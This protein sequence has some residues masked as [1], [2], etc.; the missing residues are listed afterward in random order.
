MLGL[1][2]VSPAAARPLAHRSEPSPHY[3]YAK[4]C[5]LTVEVERPEPNSDDF[6]PALGLRILTPLFD[7]PVRLFMRERLFKGRLVE[8]MAIQPGQRILDVGCG[9]GTLAL[10]IKE[11]HPQSEVVGLDPDPQ[12][13]ALTR[14]EAVR[15][16]F[17]VSF[18]VGYADR[19]P[20]PDAGF[21]R[22]T[23]SLVF[24]HLARQTKRAAFAE[25]YRVLRPGGEL[26]IADIGRAG[27]VLMRLAVRPIVLL[28]GTDRV[29]ATLR[30][31][32]PHS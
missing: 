24:H 15:S 17:E 1:A 10:L 18:D 31:V 11:R 30:A 5:S 32:S 7:P 9:T 21:D 13:L 12:I 4:R 28:D 22:V 3:G 29:K 23:S 19:L 2:G 16:G 27:G 20:Y 25:A 26:H 14:R 6:V 8:Q